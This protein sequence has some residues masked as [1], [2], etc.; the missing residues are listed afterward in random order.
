MTRPAHAATARVEI[1]ARIRA[2]RSPE[3]PSSAPR[4]YRA[5][6]THPAMGLADLLAGRVA[7]YGA[8]VLRCRPADAP[9]T[10]RAALGREGLTVLETSDAVVTTVTAA[11]ARTGTLVL[12][13]GPGQGPRELTLIP[14]LHLAVVA[15]DR[16]VATVPDA[17][18]TLAPGAPLTWVSGPSATSDIELRRIDGVHGPRTLIAV[19]LDDP[20]KT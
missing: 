15:P 20:S 2:A 1:L 17:I 4:G 7:D 9:A 5:A 13:H 12:D 14:D 10:I 18:A 11:I 3:R 16:I 8:R 19:I 6:G